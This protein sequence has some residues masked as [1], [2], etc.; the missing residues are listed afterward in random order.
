MSAGRGSSGRDGPTGRAARRRRDA[1]DDAVTRQRLLRA[2]TRLFSE[3]GFGAVTVRELCREARA[4]LAA[5]NYHFG[6]KLGLYREVVENALAG[7]RDDPTIDVPDGTPA[8]ERLRHYIR[9]YVPR[10]AA[11][12][13][14]AVWAQKLMRHEMT[15]PTPLA[16][17]IAQ[18]VILPRVRFLSE[19]VAELLGT[20]VEDERV[21][22]CVVSLQAQCLF[23]LPNR[24]REVAF[25]GWRDTSD[26]A[27]AAA[28]DHIA[29]FTLAGI[30]RTK[31]QP[32]CP[33]RRSADKP[34]HPGASGH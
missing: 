6:G 29:A 16:P 9:T 1:H 17:W 26:E 8:E 32:P 14:R 22:R 15:D 20:D 13:G 12:R 2:A 7:V 10:L 21:G 28:A 30:R 18:E 19:A 33:A 11:P 4:N 34:P 23:Y 27:I 5:V 24:F 25:P 3:R 31:E